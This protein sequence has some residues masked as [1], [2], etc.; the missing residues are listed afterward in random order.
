MGA[1][2]AVALG[3]VLVINVNGAFFAARQTDVPAIDAR[4]SV[5]R[6]I[7]AGACVVTDVTAYVVNAN[8]F[9]D[10]PRSCPD[11]V[12][13]LGMTLALNHGRRPTSDLPATS[14]VV[15]T[16]LS[17]LSR[18]DYLILSGDTPERLP[19]TPAI[20]QYVQTH[21]IALPVTGLGGVTI[22]QRIPIP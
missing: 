17:D 13:A 16:W 18:C 15:Q 9:D 3:A 1:V 11:V 20:A 7:P 8:R 12:D 21:F 4:V 19:W 2:V 10:S 5:D 14:V 6:A 22:Y